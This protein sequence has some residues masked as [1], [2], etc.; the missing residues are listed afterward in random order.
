M[1]IREGDI[2]IPRL[3]NTEPLAVQLRHFVGVVQGREAPRA[4]ARDGVRVVRVLEAASR[5]L[6]EGGIPMTIERT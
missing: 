6:A 4:D 2:F 1:A 3:P 5:S